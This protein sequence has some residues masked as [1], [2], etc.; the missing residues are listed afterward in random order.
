MKTSQN[1]KIREL[2]DRKDQNGDKYTNA[3]KELLKQYSGAGGEKVAERGILDEYYTN[4]EVANFMYDLALNYG[5]KKGK[6]LEPSIG[7]GNLIEPFYK[8]N[9]FK[10][11]TAFEINHYSKRI[12]EILYPK[13]ELH[14]LFFETVFLQQ[15][16]FTSKAKQP[17]IGNDFDLVIGNPPYGVLNGKYVSYFTEKRTFKQKELFF[18]YK[19]LQLLKS[20]GMLVFLIPQNFMRNGNSYNKAKI[21]I[22]KIA[23]FTDA[24]RLP[25]AFDKTDIGTDILILEKL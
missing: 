3:D 15:P 24:Y 20:G 12:C 25:K 18:I 11:I 10:S 9:N 13:I 6:V 1:I 5:Y 16:R 8:N 7:T 17:W 2:I 22:S 21:E 4:S 19:S 14:N 23:K